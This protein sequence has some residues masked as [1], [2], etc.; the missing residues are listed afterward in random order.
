MDKHKEAYFKYLSNNNIKQSTQREFVLDI[1]VAVD[2]HITAQG[3]FEKVKSERSNI[4]VATV[5]RAMK[6]FCDAGIAD[7]I[8]IGD[9]SKRYEKRIG[10]KHHD[11]LICTVCGTISEFYSPKLEEIQR[12]IC[13]E[14]SFELHDHSL[15]LYG[16]CSKCKGNEK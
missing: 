1:F 16:I 6:L 10:R 7:E 9:G 2:N 8:D 5:Y 14:N 13:S 3:L 11:H 12:S 15:R 4:G